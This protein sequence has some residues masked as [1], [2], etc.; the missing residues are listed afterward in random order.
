LPYGNSVLIVDHSDV[1]ILKERIAHPDI[2]G[3]GEAFIRMVENWLF[4]HTPMGET[5]I[6]LSYDDL[7]ILQNW[8]DRSI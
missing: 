8:I 3:N 2:I 7:S 5:E 1:G 6:Q 4:I